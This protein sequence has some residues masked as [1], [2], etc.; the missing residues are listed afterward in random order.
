MNR[1]VMAAMIRPMWFGWINRRATNAVLGGSVSTFE[2]GQ[3]RRS[4]RTVGLPISAEKQTISKACRRDSA[5]NYF[6]R[7]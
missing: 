4:D 5:L 3:S 7:A 1:D 6:V 2:R